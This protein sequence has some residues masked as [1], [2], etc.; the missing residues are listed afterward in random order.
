MYS[1]QLKQYISCQWGEEKENAQPEFEPE[2][3]SSLS[4]YA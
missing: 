3:P 1:K 2:V 4:D